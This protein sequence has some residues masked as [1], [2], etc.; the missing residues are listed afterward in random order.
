MCK[1]DE[2]NL[3]N[4]VRDSKHLVLFIKGEIKQKKKKP[5]LV[6]YMGADIGVWPIFL[7]PTETSWHHQ[8]KEILGVI[9]SLY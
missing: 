4:C 5:L 8:Q 3:P 7:S 6:Y 1:V 9:L 2:T